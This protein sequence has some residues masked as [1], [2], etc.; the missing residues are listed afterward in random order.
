MVSFSKQIEDLRE[1]LSSRTLTEILLSKA[2]T[3]ANEEKRKWKLEAAIKSNELGLL[4]IEEGDIES[5]LN[6]IDYNSRK[7][8][9]AVKNLKMVKDENQEG[10]LQELTYNINST[11]INEIENII[12][13]T[14]KTKQEEN[15]KLHKNIHTKENVFY[16]NQKVI[17][18]HNTNKQ[19]LIENR[20]LFFEDVKTKCS[21]NLNQNMSVVVLDDS[22][23]E[24]V[25]SDEFEGKIKTEVEN[26]DIRNE[27]LTTKDDKEN[28]I[29]RNSSNYYDAKEKL[30]CESKIHIESSD[31]NKKVTFSANTVSPLKT[32]LRKCKRVIVSKP[33]LFT[34]SIEK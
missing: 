18:K 34:T 15:L 25:V 7:K 26:L 28:S 14:N 20:I 29:I 8:L 2:L 6:E 10:C 24:K 11:N 9:K 4:Q 31:L 3:E 32:A 13:G 1:Q 22:C 27:K 21:K 19:N 30:P 33:V 17:E 16:E 5:N 23:D 12:S